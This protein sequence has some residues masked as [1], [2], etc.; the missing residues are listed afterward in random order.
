MG[1][2]K[3]QQQGCQASSREDRSSRKSQEHQVPLPPVGVTDGYPQILLHLSIPLP[4]AFSCP[5]PFRRKAL[6]EVSTL[7]R[8]AEST[9]PAGSVWHAVQEDTRVRRCPL[10]LLHAYCS[11]VKAGCTDSCVAYEP[12]C[13]SLFM[14][15]KQLLLQPDPL[16]RK[17][18]RPRLSGS[19]GHLLLSRRKGAIYD[20]RLDWT[21]TVE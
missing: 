14:G 12:P 7:Q 21:C 17:H 1:K 20:I 13:P 11:K 6:G 3:T 16:P 5:A 4:A 8:P 19:C 2:A 15:Q 18:G 10:C 9:V